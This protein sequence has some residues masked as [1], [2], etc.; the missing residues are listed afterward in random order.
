MEQQRSVLRI[1]RVGIDHDGRA[2][3]WSDESEPCPRTVL[4]PRPRGR[5]L[6]ELTVSRQDVVDAHRASSFRKRL[7]ELAIPIEAT[8]DTPPAAGQGQDP[9]AARPT[10]EPCAYPCVLV[11]VDDQKFQSLLE[12][13]RVLHRTADELTRSPRFDEHVR[14]RL[15]WSRN[16]P[17]VP[18]DQRQ[19]ADE[20]VEVLGSARLSATQSRRLH[21]AFFKR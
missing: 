15:S 19:I 5:E 12:Q 16:V 13:V 7:P 11:S 4:M 3:H 10:E 9:R 2:R 8:P 18:S 1:R 20:V 17:S 14:A 21:E 6:A